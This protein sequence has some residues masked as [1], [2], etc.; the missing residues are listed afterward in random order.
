MQ[1]L[2][3]ALYSTPHVAIRE[4]VQNGH[5]S[6]ERRRHEDEAEFE[7]SIDVECDAAAH[8]LTVRDNGA[9]LTDSEVR[10]Y[11]ATVGTGYTRQL[12]EKTQDAGLIGYFGLGFLSAYVVAERTQVW[13]CSYQTP[14]QAWHFASRSG[15]NFTLTEASARPI[16][17]EVKLHLKEQFHEL[18]DA[19][20][21]RELLNRYCAL[22]PH[23][24]RVG[25]EAIN[26]DPPPWR[27]SDVGA[28]RKRKLYMEFAERFETDYR[29]VTVMP[30]E[31][32]DAE[33]RGALW[34][35]DGGSFATS[36]NRNVSVFVRGMLIGKK[37]REL[38]PKWAGFVGAV[39]ESDVLQPTASRETLQKDATFDRVAEYVREQ[40]IDAMARVAKHESA[41]WRRV[42]LR[43]NEALLGAALSD[44]RLF[45]LLADDVTVP[46][47]QGDLTIGRVL[48]LS[49][50]KIHVAQNE[51]GG[52]EELLFGALKV[53]VVHGVRFGALPFCREY[54]ERRRGQLVVLGTDNDRDLF[55]PAA[56]DDEAT[57]R[58][59]EWFAAAD[60]EVVLSRFQPPDLPFVLIPDREVELKRKIESDEAD[61][62]IG[63][64]LLG[65]A[66]IHTEKIHDGAVQ[67]LYVNVDCPAIQALLSAEEP[68]LSLA[69][70]L[71]RPLESLL[72]DTAVQA[73]IGGALKD[74]GKALCEVLKGID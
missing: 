47:S 53:P 55:R 57:G 20:L 8:T 27:L 74:Y 52:F 13:T 24:V 44:A 33:I 4:L 5:D 71:L 64:A 26:P 40:L 34:L 31:E 39:L 15:Q 42:L 19:S 11:L 65:L 62:R 22:L 38:L 21:L 73:D 59:K 46:T 6:C 56:L 72:A 67:K 37:E 29:P 14:D 51:R 58:I 30:L 2:G 60:R 1:V 10:D 63:S 45:D 54:V 9:G 35:Q 69:L 50:G 23:T 68:R 32:S 25:G 16:G 66:R 43:H 3:E 28:L 12:R 41:A 61:R 18:A 49:K 36:D 17:T 7:P 48:E 70:R